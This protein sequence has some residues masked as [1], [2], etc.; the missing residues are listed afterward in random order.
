MSSLP[1]DFKLS[2]PPPDVAD[3]PPVASAHFH[4]TSYLLGL[5]T[6]LILVGG[7]LFFLRHP[8]P[9]PIV[10]HAP[11]PPAPTAT[12]LPPPTPA[13]IM[14]FVSGAVQKPGLYNLTADERVGDALAKAGGFTATA[15][16]SLINQA[17]KLQDGAQVYVPDLAESAAT[18]QPP[19][20]VTE[21]VAQTGSADSGNAPTGPINLN[22]AT[23]AQLDS[24]PGIGPSKAAAIVAN[25]PY[26]TVD[27]LDKVPGIGPSILEQVRPL[28]TVQ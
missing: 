6:S 18:Q 13:P 12:A 3:S 24:L 9:P 27:E 10:L 1:H 7:A 28:V 5:L 14:V 26:A 15:N 21:P 23:P 4:F 16:A 2:T 25:R 11:P 20:G 19:A 22:T 17:A 8:D